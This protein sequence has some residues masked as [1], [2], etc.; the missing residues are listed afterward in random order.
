MHLRKRLTSRRLATLLGGVAA[1]A[2]LVPSALAGTT[3]WSGTATDV[4]AA[5]EPA[6][7]VRPFAAL[8]DGADFFLAPNGGFEQGADGWTLTGPATIQTVNE[9]FFVRSADDTRSLRL[10]R[11]A[12]VTSPATCVGKQY[13]YARLVVS[14]S[15]RAELRV[16]VV[17]VDRKGREQVDRV[18]TLKGSGA[19]EL[20][21][22]LDT[23]SNPLFAKSLLQ[24][25]AGTTAIAF[26]FTVISG[27]WAI[28]DLHVDPFKLR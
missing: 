23:R 26:R 13:P 17:S 6:E 14:G 19:W 18:R 4:A 24:S 25:G 7:I 15:P 27:T 16:S 20:S 1:C 9:P 5:W 10:E 2:A 12:T 3:P 8:G 11:G 28:D 22:K 21:D